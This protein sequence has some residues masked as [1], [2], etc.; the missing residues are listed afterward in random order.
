MNEG[1][2]MTCPP[3]GSANRWVA[4]PNED[5]LLRICGESEPHALRTTVFQKGKAAGRRRSTLGKEQER[6]HSEEKHGTAETKKAMSALTRLLGEKTWQ[7]NS[8]Q[9]ERRKSGP[10]EKANSTNDNYNCKREVL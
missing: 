6:T 8:G 3:K 1:S 2:E 10:K 5:N 7:K 9:T 4:L